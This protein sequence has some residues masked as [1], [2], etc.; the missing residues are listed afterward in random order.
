MCMREGVVL[1]VGGWRWACLHLEG[2]ANGGAAAACVW[3]TPELL[4]VRTDW[5]N[6]RRR[7]RQSRSLQGPAAAR[8][9]AVGSRREAGRLVPV[10]LVFLTFPFCCL[11]APSLPSPSFGPWYVHVGTMHAAAANSGGPTGLWSYRP[12]PLLGLCPACFWP[13]RRLLTNVESF[14]G[15]WKAPA[16]SSTHSCMW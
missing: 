9:L 5:S 2:P 8:L 4:V 7:R 1:L 3:K 12:W 10:S 14:R 13:C 6:E 16:D 15:I 11:L